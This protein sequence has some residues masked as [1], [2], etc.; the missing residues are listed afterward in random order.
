MVG[1][2][3]PHEKVRAASHRVP[4]D[5]ADVADHDA[6]DERANH[7]AADEPVIPLTPPLNHYCSTR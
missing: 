6:E 7:L 2:T 5:L 1:V 3:D 4:D